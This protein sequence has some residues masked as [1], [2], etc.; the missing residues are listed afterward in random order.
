MDYSQYFKLLK[1]KN[2]GGLFLFHGPEE[3][4]K[5]S[6]LLQTIEQVDTVARDLNVLEVKAP[7]AQAVLDACETL[8]FFAERRLVICYEMADSELKLLL[9]KAKDIPPTT[10]LIIY[11]RGACKKDIL[12]LAKPFDV[13][14][15]QLNES[16]ALRF[17]EKRA[18]AANA[19]LSSACAR[20]IVEMVGTEAHTLQNELLKLTQYVGA[21]GEITP[22]IIRELITPSPEYEFFGLL[23]KLLSGKK[24][25]GLIAFKHMLKNDPGSAFLLAHS[26]ERQL[27][28]MYG[29][30][31]LLDA[32]VNERDI[33][34]KLALKPWAA[35]TALRGARRMTAKT[36]KA[37]LID[38]AQVDHL[39][40]SGQMPAAQALEIAIL[41]YF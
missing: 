37:A 21:D 34:Q 5:Q 30:R 23:D 35:R 39:Q 8:P 25:Q 6:A 12:T 19:R 40:V 16:E 26:F 3:F 24:A 29:A 7:A 9:P 14:F 38:F 10:T 15:D 31:L 33:P 4:V 18:R 32:N 28:N 1:E 17:V 36:L 2:T 22:E 11:V 41:K 27:K 13:L 20:L